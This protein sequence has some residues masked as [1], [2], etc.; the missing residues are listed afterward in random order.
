MKLA[1]KLPLA[2]A[3][4]LLLMLC[5]ALYG[6][7]ELNRS[8]ITF[9]TEVRQSTND[10]GAIRGMQID[11][12]EQVVEWKNVLL[13]GK[14]PAAL[15]KYWNGFV[16]AESNVSEAV[17][18]LIST[19]TNVEAKKGLQQFGTEH[20]ALGEKYRTALAAFKADDFNSA[21]GDGL[22]KGMDQEAQRLIKEVGVTLTKDAEVISDA[23]T[24]SAKRGLATS[25]ILM[26]VV[27]GVVIFGSLWI[28][29]AITKSLNEA[30][31]F[32]QAVAAG[33]LTKQISVNGKDEV[34][35]LLGAVGEMQTSLTKV[36]SNVRANAN[37][38]AL[39]S[40][41]IAQGNHDLS[42]RT[43]QQASALEETAASMEELSSTV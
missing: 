17:K 16:K 9:K 31:E 43:E 7:F 38:V 25:L 18:K 22:V 33:D 37:S 32:A 14:D 23:A 41:E 28:S 27:C 40:A 6:I 20:A 8:L 39:A 42:A 29:R 1:L 13:R 19:E 26:F 12:K 3:F 5:S 24:V 4:A 21:T 35:Q 11:F 36:L 2:F 10:R 15:E 30:V 34:A